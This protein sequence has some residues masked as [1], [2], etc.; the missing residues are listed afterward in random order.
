M[1]IYLLFV[2]LGLG[3]GSVYALLA[4]GLVLKYRST[5][6]VDFAQ[7]AVAMFCAYVFLSL[8]NFGT[9]QLPWV[10]L[11]HEV[12]VAPSGLATVPALAVTLVYGALLGLVL[13]VLVF[14]P[15]L[16]A[17]PLTKVCAAAGVM[18][19]LTAVAVLN[20]G[21]TAQATPAVLPSRPMSIAGIAFPSDR[22]YL[23]SIVVVIAAVLALIYQRTSF[24]LATRAAAENDTGAALIGIS[25]SSVAGRNWVLASVLAALSGVLITPISSLSPASYTLFVVPA[26]GAALLGRFTSFW[27]TAAAGLGLGITQSLL[28]K[29]QAVFTWLPQQGLADG[30]PFLIILI[31]MTL[32]AKRIGARGST[33]SWRNPS[34]GRPT[35]PLATSLVS[36]VLGAALLVLLH[37]SLRAAFMASLVAICLCLSL[38][39]L[40][41]YVGQ[42]SLAQMAFAGMG[43]FILSHL[44]D[45]AGVPFP[46]SLLLAALAVVPLGVLIG[47]P[48]LRVRGVNLAVVTLAAAAAID[49]L[50]FSDV[51]FTGGLGGR[52]IPSP[53]LLGIDVGVAKG[54]D[55][56]RVAWGLVLLAIVVFVGYCVARL[57]TSATGRMLLAVRSNERAASSVGIRVAPV[58]LYAFALSSFIAGLGGGLLAYTQGTVSSGAFGAFA[59]L[60]LLAVAY[61][62]GIGRIAGAVIAGLMFASDGLL[63]SL[64]DKTLHVGQYST[65]VAGVALAFTAIKNPDGVAAELAGDRGLAPRVVA[66]RDRILPGTVG[67]APAP[68][69]RTASVPV[70]PSLSRKAHR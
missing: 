16:Q 35:R 2:L 17:A 8:R 57:R 7:G 30:V 13:F 23:A 6:V 49:A 22:L 61:V 41:G 20:F 10:V 21:T 46:L 1:S 34:L 38:V 43:A 56:P 67:R 54:G 64:V 63:V 25:A 45:S 65:L 9:L 11:P 62:A 31:A 40:T 12:R 52:T 4:L 42:V 5:G 29:L 66:W 39:V 59:S 15:L 51:G 27:W 69:T 68:T 36:M 14:R 3:A 48:A 37:G 53:T 33:G 28:I 18:L 47:L 44:I 32:S 60:S 19:A 26:L 58:K 50:V 70:A 24:G 55:Y